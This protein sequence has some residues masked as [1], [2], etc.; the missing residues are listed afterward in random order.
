MRYMVSVSVATT[1]LPFA[2]VERAE[3]NRWPGQGI[4]EQTVEEVARSEE[5]KDT[6]T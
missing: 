3:K 5:G 1:C 2:L 6:G 4:Y